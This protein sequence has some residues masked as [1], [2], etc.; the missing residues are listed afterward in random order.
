MTTRSE[1]QVYNGAKVFGM[2]GEINGKYPK[3][4]VRRNDQTE[5]GGVPSAV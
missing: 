3:T 1:R 5:G 4:E 2:G